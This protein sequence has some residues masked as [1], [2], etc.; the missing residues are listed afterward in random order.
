MADIATVTSLILGPDRVSGDPA[1]GYRDSREV[2]R[3][4]AVA[5]DRDSQ[6]NRAALARLDRLLAA[7]QPLDPN[8]PRG[9]YLNIRI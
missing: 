4:A 9:H 2:E 1:R 6:R 8:V 3:R 5:Q 7:G